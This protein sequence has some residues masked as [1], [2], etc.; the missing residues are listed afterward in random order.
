MEE[1]A[2]EPV[3][4]VPITLFDTVVLAARAVDGT[5]WLSVSDLA[6]AVSVDPRTQRRR[7][8][9][10][11]ILARHARQFRAATAGGSQEQLFLK[12]EGVG[13][14][15]MTINAARVGDA[16]RERL[17]WLQQHLEDAVR[18]AFAVATGLPE[19]SSDIEE[20]DDLNRIDSIL[21]GIVRQQGEILRRQDALAQTIADIAARLREQ[22]RPQQP[23]ASTISKA[24]RG[25]IYN[26]V[27]EWS[28]LLQQRNE[29]MTVGAARAT[30][31]AVFKR[32]FKLAEYHH[33][34]AARYNEAI[35]FIRKACRELG[36]GDLPAQASLELGDQ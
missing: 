3:E 31:W 17:I 11:P 35:E 36:G 29:G 32:T 23:E 12:L 20:I 27:L 14:W 33:L 28:A 5:L 4:Q 6:L 15:V 21:A 24:Q 8:Q 13:L 2:L 7:V 34:P 19:R 1:P 10:N 25:Q 18:K 9:A 16:V 26:L 22:E 30:C